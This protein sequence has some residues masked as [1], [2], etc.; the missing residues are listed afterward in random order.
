METTDKQDITQ[1]IEEKK[2]TSE[3]EYKFDIDEFLKC[4]EQIQ[5]DKKTKGLFQNLF[6]M[7]SIN[8]IT[9]LCVVGVFGYIYGVTFWA[10]QIS[11]SHLRFV[12]QSLGNLYGILNT[13]IGFYCG[14]VYT[15][16]KNNEYK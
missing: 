10:D 4:F 2:K 15:K 9:M 3:C 11:E 8:V 16:S 12:D 6:N 1:K 7:D 5:Q 14:N 13:I